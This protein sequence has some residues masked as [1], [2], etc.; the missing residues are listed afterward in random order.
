MEWI[1][2]YKPQRILSKKQKILEYII[3]DTVIKVG[4]EHIWLWM[5]IEPTV[6]KL[7]HFNPKERNM[8]LLKSDF[9]LML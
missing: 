8:F 7:F 2:K 6:N 9:Y 5:A 1:Q 4:S 3:N